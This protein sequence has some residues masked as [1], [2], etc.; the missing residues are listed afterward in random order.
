[1]QKV[2]KNAM[3][4]CAWFESKD[5][6]LYGQRVIPFWRQIF[7][8]EVRQIPSCFAVSFSGRQKYL[9]I[10]DMP[11]DCQEDIS[12][13]RNLALCHVPAI[14]VI[15]DPSSSVRTSPGI[16]ESVRRV[17]CWDDGFRL[18]FPPLRSRIRQ[19]SDWTCNGSGLRALDHRRVNFQTTPLTECLLSSPLPGLKCLLVS[20]TGQHLPMWFI[21]I[22]CSN[23]S[24]NGGQLHRAL[25]NFSLLGP[26]PV[27]NLLK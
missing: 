19:F 8:S 13:T 23:Q 12:A 27:V 18:Y 22:D 9:E 1:M 24:S 3:C 26:Q 11:I 4:P 20:K 10:S 21:I 7:F 25:R 14:M 16:T 17:R 6:F 5:T 15:K 2:H